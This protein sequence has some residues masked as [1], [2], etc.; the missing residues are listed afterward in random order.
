MLKLLR[1]KSFRKSKDFKTPSDCTTASRSK[2][3][4]S[5]SIYSTNSAPQRRSFSTERNHRHRPRNTSVG[6]GG[7]AGSGSKGLQ[8]ED[9]EKDLLVKEGGQYR[10]TSVS[11]YSFNQSNAA[12]S[13]AAN[14]DSR[15]SSWDR[16][17]QGSGQHRYSSVVSTNTL[18]ANSNAALGRGES[19]PEILQY[20]RPPENLTSPVRESSSHLQE[21]L[22]PSP[23][24]V[25]KTQDE[26]RAL[27]ERGGYP[28]TGSADAQPVKR[29]VIAALRQSF[30]RKSTGSSRQLRE[31]T[32]KRQQGTPQ[33]KNSAPFAV[34][35]QHA[36]ATVSRKI[37]TDSA[38]SSVHTPSSRRSGSVASAI[39]RTAST[40]GSRGQLI[41]GRAGSP[42]RSAGSKPTLV[43]PPF[44]QTQTPPA[45]QLSS[46]QSETKDA[47]MRDPTTFSSHRSS[48]HH[49]NNHHSIHGT[50]NGAAD[51]ERSAIVTPRTARCLPQTPKQP[52]RTGLT[53]PTTPTG[54]YPFS[55]DH[56]AHRSSAGGG[57]K[58]TA[59]VSPVPA[60]AAA[61]ASVLRESSASAAGRGGS[62]H[63]AHS[64]TH[65]VAPRPAQR[66][67][68]RNK[69]RRRCVTK[70]D[71]CGREERKNPN[72]FPIT[73]FSKEVKSIC[74]VFF[75]CAALLLWD[76]CLHKS[77]P[78][79]FPFFK[80][81]VFCLPL[82]LIFVRFCRRE[83]KN[84]N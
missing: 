60:S 7:I 2:S 3:S 10:S 49:H 19:P 34:S 58:S 53:T 45:Q 14:P 81:D 6:G 4:D 38:R 51:V 63:H 50:S 40:S 20:A 71:G 47:E 31:Q 54:A 77:V 30:R 61:V 56:G 62:D 36:H 46:D 76:F 59:V 80:V 43:V 69:V 1:R 8:S 44:Q 17:S 83:K 29:G 73:Y 25:K 18:G 24:T 67:S 9:N 28:V 66:L 35:S 39:N 72:Y 12:V 5:S 52:S 11:Q 27:L 84:M 74:S 32:R 16:R 23:G 79:F 64:N 65:T 75:S 42:G 41:P 57:T 37:S 26:S 13:A 48:A 55:S 82:T 78:R 68:L 22:T 15:Y 70:F 33:R 21:S